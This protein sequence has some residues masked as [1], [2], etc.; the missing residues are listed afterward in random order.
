MVLP[1][2][3]PRC[4][5]CLDSHPRSLSRA[6][7]IPEAIGGRLAVPFLCSRCNSQ[8]GHTVEKGLKH[9]P[10]V[11]FAFERVRPQIPQLAKKLAPGYVYA[12]RTSHGLVRARPR[13]DSYEILD[14]RQDDRSRIRDPGRAR[15]EIV[16]V[17]R[18]RGASQIEIAAALEAHD[19]APE[20]QIVEVA[21][22]IPIRKS[23]VG[24]FSPTHDGDSV[25]DDCFLGIAYLFLAIL[26]DRAIYDPALDALRQRLRGNPPSD[27]GWSAESL[28]APNSYGPW[29]GIA[30]VE[31]TPQLLVE[32]RL[33]GSE[34][35]LIRFEHMAMTSLPGGTR[36]AYRLDLATGAEDWQLD[37]PAEFGLARSP[38][39][40]A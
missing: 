21:P 17:L 35:W 16:T 24:G 8:L 11:R 37:K 3:D 25:S 14:T 4:V 39:P 2:P 5:L 40:A 34:S 26:V 7:I 13:G 23:S 20:D 22:G 18:R 28:L 6:H 12:T 36:P 32:V 9:D 27:P 30:V 33:F 38:I 29:H 10:R 15:D 1:W 31:F 19:N